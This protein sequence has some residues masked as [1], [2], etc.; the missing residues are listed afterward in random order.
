MKMSDIETMAKITSEKE[1][2]VYCEKL[3]W[4]KKQVS[5]IKL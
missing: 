5:A 1:I 3:G 2:K 4:D